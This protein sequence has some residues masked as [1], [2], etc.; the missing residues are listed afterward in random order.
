MRNFKLK[1]FGR[2]TPESPRQYHR[3]ELLRDEAL[4]MS[5]KELIEFALSTHE[6]ISELTVTGDMSASGET[7]TLRD[8]LP[9]PKEQSNA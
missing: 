9:A 7:K 3:K 8:I 2:E 5:D 4:H 1:I 6:E